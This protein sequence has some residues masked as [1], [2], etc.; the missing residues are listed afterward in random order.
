MRITAPPSPQ[1][2]RTTGAVQALALVA[3]GLVLG[4]GPTA[5]ASASS[6][7]LDEQPAAATVFQLSSFNLLGAAHTAPGGNKPDF[8]S[9]TQRMVWATQILDEEG[10]DV[11]GFQE[12][13]QPQY[14]KFMALRG[15]SFGIYPGAE[16]DN[17]AMSN[18]IARRKA[19]WSLV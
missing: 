3:G 18:S 11:V 17:P 14:E 15:S 12:M 13:E 16:V 5:G 19:N 7:R 4:L 8:A 6:A 2:I 9:G 1:R 10:V